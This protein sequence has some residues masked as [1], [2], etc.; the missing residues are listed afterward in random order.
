MEQEVRSSVASQG[1]EVGENRDGVTGS[2]GDKE[3]EPPGR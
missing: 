2:P 1:S 3:K